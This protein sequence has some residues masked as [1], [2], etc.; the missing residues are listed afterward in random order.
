M[1]FW[2]VDLSTEDGAMSAAGV[3]SYACFIAAALGAIG[4]VLMIA[5]L[6]ASGGVELA[7]I[8]GFGLAV[9]V[10]V[11]AGFRFR[12]GRGAAWGALAA[13]LIVAE[14]G[15]R[16]LTMNGLLGIIFDLLFLAA[17]VTGIRGVLVL[18]HGA[19]PHAT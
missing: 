17:I 10:F 3:G 8:S 2:N 9:L 14:M 16:L 1:A 19:S 12:V 13:I 11:V 7:M 18:R 4:L 15:F 6:N 5:G